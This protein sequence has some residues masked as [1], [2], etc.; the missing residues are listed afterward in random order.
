MEIILNYKW[1]KKILKLHNQHATSAD[2]VH[3]VRR[4]TNSGGIWNYKDKI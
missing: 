2:F 3:V 4:G 1:I